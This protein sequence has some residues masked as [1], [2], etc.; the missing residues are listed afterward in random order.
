MVIWLDGESVLQYVSIKCSVKW[1]VDSSAN[2]MYVL[3]TVG[4]DKSLVASV[5]QFLV[6]FF[7]QS[8]ATHAAEKSPRNRNFLYPQIHTNKL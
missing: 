1:I 8:G 7:Y 5:N 4:A 6:V 2:F 3:D